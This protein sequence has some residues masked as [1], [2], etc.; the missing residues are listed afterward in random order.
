MAKVSCLLTGNVQG[1]AA[2]A[3]DGIL[4]GAADGPGGG[5]GGGG[6]GPAGEG[7]AVVGAGGGELQGGQHL[8]QRRSLLTGI[9]RGG[10]GE[11][12]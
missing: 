2:P 10:G 11:E 8:A 3:P 12:L 1:E 7:G 9:V 4:P 6:V 5:G